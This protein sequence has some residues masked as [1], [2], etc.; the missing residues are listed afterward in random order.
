MTRTA[1]PSPRP[2]RSETPLAAVATRA[3]GALG[4]YAEGAVGALAL[5]GIVTGA[6]GVALAG[7]ERPSFLSPSRLHGDAPWLAGP[8]AGRWPSLTH[9]VGSLRWDVTL[10]LLAMT[11][12][13]ALAVACA[14]RVRLPGVLAAVALS[15]LALTLA[16]PFSLTDTF[17]YLHYGRMLPL[18][19]L[20]PYT[21]LPIQAAADPAYPYSTWH[22]LPSPYGPLFTLL[23]E[24][25]APFGLATAYWI[26]KVAIGLAALAVAGLTVALA[27]AL[28]RDPARAVAFVALNPLVLVYGVGGVHNDVLF[29]AL[30][31]GGALLAVRRRELLG[32][33]AWA[34]A[35]AIKL[36]A[37]LA[38]PVLVAGAGRRGRAAIGVALGGAAM[39]V[40][41]W[42]AFRGHLPNDADQ[43]R[44][45]ASLSAPNLLG[46]AAGRGGLDAQLRGELDVALVL[47]SAGLVLWTWRTRDWITATAW[48]M[49]LLIV[50]LGWAMPWYVLWVLPFA[51]L[52]RRAA[53]RAAA[54]ALT[55]FLLAVWAPAT[56]PLLHRLGA[57]PGATA[58]GR[59]NAR[60]LHTLLR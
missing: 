9:L 25:L 10:A 42:L 12:C 39:L 53:P 43:A 8:L 38:I 23:M 24:L 50:T 4:S 40:M 41:T 34:F 15:D 1:A 13:W 37:G 18:F 45:V 54:I 21:A 58:V 32:G 5:T 22:H 7:A 49:A 30:L 26:L 20:N 46:L 31:L 11:A 16:P 44:L 51:A 35:A 59:D 29:M 36:S 27:R 3:R 14:Q 52:S 48:A 28:G 55:V 33:S 6:L 19:G 17:N 60:F 2:L 47:V 56:P 57:R